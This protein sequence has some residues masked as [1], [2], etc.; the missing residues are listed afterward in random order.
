MFFASKV[1]FLCA[2]YVGTHPGNL[3]AQV[4]SGR[5]V[6]ITP[7]ALCRWDIEDD[8]TPTS[9]SPN[10]VFCVET[11]RICY[12]SRWPKAT[13]RGREVHKSRLV[14]SGAVERAFCQRHCDAMRVSTWK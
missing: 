6:R 1:T 4:R 7:P 8:H 3:S 12:L 14:S 13:T 9:H 2:P 10:R 5:D 11:P